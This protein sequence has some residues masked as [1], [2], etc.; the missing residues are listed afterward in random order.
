MALTPEDALY[1]AIDSAGSEAKKKYRDIIHLPFFFVNPI[2]QNESF[3]DGYAITEEDQV[4][5]YRSNEFSMRSPSFIGSTV[6]LNSF[7]VIVRDLRKV[8]FLVHASRWNKDGSLQR[9][10]KAIITVMQKNDDWRMISRNPFS[11]IELE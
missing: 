3:Q 5:E 8:A 1:D 4:P 9:H 2:W 7:E 10:F 11:G 6:K